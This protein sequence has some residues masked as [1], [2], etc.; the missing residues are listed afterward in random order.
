M[1]NHCMHYGIPCDSGTDGNCVCR[2]RFFAPS[3]T[4]EVGCDSVRSPGC[5]VAGCYRY[6]ERDGYC[7]VHLHHAPQASGEAKS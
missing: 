1:A 3:P 5:R 7:R 6:H 4:H 2:Q